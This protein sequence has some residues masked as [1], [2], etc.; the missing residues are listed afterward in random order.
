MSVR[1]KLAERNSGGPEFRIEPNRLIVEVND[2][3]QLSGN[4][5]FNKSYSSIDR[6]LERVGFS[7]KRLSNIGALEIQSDAM[8][9]VVS[10]MQDMSD[11][12]SSSTVNALESLMSSAKSREGQTI[13]GPMRSGVLDFQQS[14]R[15]KEAAMRAELMSSGL[16]NELT[17]AIEDID[18]VLNV[19]MELVPST[20]GPRSLNVDIGKSQFDSDEDEDSSK[21]DVGDALEKMGVP[22]A[23]EEDDGEGAIAA[24]FDT[25]F[26]PD[27]LDVPRVRAAFSGEDAETP[28]SAPD[29]GHG[30]MTAYSMA[31]NKNES[32][33][34]YHGA[35]KGAE[36]L[37]ARLS[38][39]SG[40]LV[41]ISEAW[42][43]LVGQI[44]SAD[45]PVISNHSYGT[46]VC[47]GRGMDMCQSTTTRLVQA[48]NK[49]DDHQAFYAAGNEGVY[50]GHRLSGVT[51]GINGANSAPESLTCGALRFDLQDA[52][53]YSSHGYGTC[54]DFSENPKPDLSCL[55]PQIVPYGNKEKDMSTG[56]GGS[57]GGT[58]EAT[59]L[60][61][62]VATLVASK[63]GTANRDTLESLLETT[64]QRVRRTQVNF[65]VGHDARFGHGQVR[66][67]RAMEAAINQTDL[68]ME[69]SDSSNGNGS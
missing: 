1:G 17:M 12:F 63:L 57:S 19:D 56:V 15:D 44:R 59:P 24:I 40:G 35:A 55:L 2:L 36:L 10:N 41:Y 51:N 47:G 27:F 26:S 32:G 20:F 16:T 9:D 61:A 38:D 67:D 25:S 6:T 53:T 48:L 7:V 68:P 62:G 65:L 58:S 34:G 50:C 22:D 23:W 5:N 3:E 33:L 21:T 8:F 60:T 13:T 69:D 43:W 64:A 14:D 37:L 11:M 45:K 29:E 54:T 49:R 42:D 46:P 30:T 4:L 52:Q 39:S 66:A 18:G 28:F 31:G